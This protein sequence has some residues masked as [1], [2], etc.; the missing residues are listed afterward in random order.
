MAIDEDIYLPGCGLCDQ[1]ILSS[2]EK[3]IIDGDDGT[4]K[5][6]VHRKCYDAH[7]PS[8]KTIG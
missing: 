3:K 7:Y 2:Q 8:E 6:V 4:E 1:A 5:T